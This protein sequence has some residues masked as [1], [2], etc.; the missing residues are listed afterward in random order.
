[1]AIQRVDYL[2][3]INSPKT[4]GEKPNP[5]D[6]VNIGYLAGRFGVN[7]DGNLQENNIPK[8]TDNGLQININSCTTELL[9][10][11]LNKSGIKFNRLA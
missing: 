9:E 7:L 8:Y 5:Q 11:N 3:H 4:N 6:L 10:E 1:M 2:I